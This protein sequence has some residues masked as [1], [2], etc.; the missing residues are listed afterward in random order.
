MT[1]TTQKCRCGWV[2]DNDPLY[3]EYHDS[4]WGIPS[5][6]ERYLFE[7]LCLEG[8]QAGLSW[9]TVLRKRDNYRKAFDSFDPQKIIRYDEKK[10]ASLMQ[11]SGIIRNR[12]KIQ[13]VIGNARAFL[14]IQKEFGS[15][16]DYIWGFTNG[17]QVVSHLANFRDMPTTS[18][19][20]DTI[21]KDLK[22]RGMKFVGSTIIY[23]YLQAIG[24]LNDHET[25]C[26]K[27][28]ETECNFR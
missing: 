13:S 26:F 23:S 17:K 5:H 18:P 25:G 19:L 8:A 14:A 15:F 3:Q 12:L 21:S 28:S 27:V 4:E 11:N 6:D 20:S 16:N 24:V 1:H 9:I 7:M 10:I 2:P 22:K